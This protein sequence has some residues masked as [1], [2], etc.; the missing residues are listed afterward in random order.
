MQQA[1]HEEPY[2][3]TQIL[4]GHPFLG[5]SWR[6]LHWTEDCTC[7]RA[8][9][10]SPMSSSASHRGSH[11]G[12]PISETPS[13]TQMNLSAFRSTAACTATS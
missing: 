10:R 6:L 7:A 5:Q 11:C 12:K 13:V 9:A 8:A 2:L 1:N 4:A 3:Q